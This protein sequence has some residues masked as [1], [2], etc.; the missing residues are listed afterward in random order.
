MAK[1]KPTAPTAGDGADLL[2]AI[3][4]RP[5]E[6]TPRLIYA[7]WLDEHKQPERA[8]FIRV[9]C[10]LA[11][12]SEYDANRPELLLRERLLLT[13]NRKSTWGELPVKPVKEKTFARGFV[14]SISVHAAKFLAG[15]GAL[16]DAVPVRELRPLKIGPAW[17]QLLASEHLLRVRSL[18]LHSSAISAKRAAE[19][20]K[21]EHLANLHELNLGANGKLGATGFRSLLASPHLRELRTLH[22]NNCHLGDDAIAA[23]V[24]C[25]TLPNLRHL[26]LSDNGIGPTGVAHLARAEWLSQL[27]RLEIDSNPLTDAGVRALADAGLLA[28]HA[29]L[30]L[31]SAGVTLE[32]LRAIGRSDGL[33]AVRELRLTGIGG[34]DVLEAVAEAPAFAHL[35]ALRLLDG[36]RVTEAGVRA[37]LRSPLAPRLRALGIGYA[38]LPGEFRELMTAPELREL[39]W[40]AANGSSTSTENRIDLGAVLR[41]ATQFTN[42][43]KMHLSTGWIKDED[44]IAL[45]G[46]AHFANLADLRIGSGRVTPAGMDAF[47]ESPHFARLRA[48]H[49]P[50]D[51]YNL[52]DP[53]R[54]RIAARFGEG[55]FSYY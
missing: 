35:S 42:L 17:N 48:V 12:G 33:G 27:D 39:Q 38:M 34:A 2:A 21:C 41:D 47:L 9:Q 50:L 20:A 5:D 18:D 54:A 15:A 8:E 23:F 1:R 22:L 25:T 6:D 10:A 13:A 4:A 40:L 29:L 53:I 19:L 44:V 3:R 30:D 16:F 43:H 55:V 7:D 32:G 49:L 52:N 45:A 24:G 11:R 36:A 31:R 14:D 51:S 46:C 28:R 37:L 26:N